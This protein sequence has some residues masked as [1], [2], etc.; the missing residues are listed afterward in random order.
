MKELIIKVAYFRFYE[1]C[2]IVLKILYKINI[3]GC[4]FVFLYLLLIATY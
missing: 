1:T 2:A 3:N 4:K